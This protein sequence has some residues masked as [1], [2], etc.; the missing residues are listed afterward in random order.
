MTRVSDVYPSLSDRYKLANNNNA[1][2]FLSVHINSAG[3]TTATGIETLWSNKN[4][5]NKAFAQSIQSQLIGQTGERDRGLKPRND[6]AVLNGTRG[7]SAL[8]ELGFINNPTDAA[9]MKTESYLDKCAT[10]LANGI[11]NFLSK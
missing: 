3:G 2:A 8:A 11:H 1:D 9:K 7:P 6:L 10:A 4:S 5:Q